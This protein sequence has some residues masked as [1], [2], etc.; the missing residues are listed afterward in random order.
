LLING[1][2]NKIKQKRSICS[3][4]PIF[5]LLEGFQKLLDILQGD[6]RGYVNILGGNIICRCEKK[7]D[8]KMWLILNS[9]RDT[10]V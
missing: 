1:K 6:S 2:N 4:F 5:R 7:P 10:D 3:E 8:K 9:Q